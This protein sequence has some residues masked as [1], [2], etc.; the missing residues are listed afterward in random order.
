[1]LP[2]IAAGGL[3]VY[4]AYKYLT[5]RVTKVCYLCN[6][7]LDEKEFTNSYYCPK[8]SLL[9]NNNVELF[10]ENYQGNKYKPCTDKE[11]ITSNHFDDKFIAENELKMIATRMGCDVVHDVRLN[12]DMHNSGNYI[13]KIWW[14][15]GIAAKR[16][17]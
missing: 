4:A 9:R 7:V 6:D 12:Y 11:R 1:M 10:S 2:I 16:G 14:A 5:R 15:E 3:A 13:Y 8:C 17:V